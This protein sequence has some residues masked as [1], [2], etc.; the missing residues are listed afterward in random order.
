MLNI[1]WVSTYVPGS[2]FMPYFHMLSQLALSWQSSFIGAGKSRE[3]GPTLWGHIAEGKAGMHFHYALLPWEV[4]TCKYIR[5][6]LVLAG[7]NIQCLQQTNDCFNILK[8]NI[9]ILNN[10]RSI[11]P[12]NPCFSIFSYLQVVLG[13]NAEVSFS[14][15]TYWAS[16]CSCNF[17]V[18]FPSASETE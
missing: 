8:S 9:I 10:F 17:I 6:I 2:Y 3:V 7:S 15:A 1:Y 18:E 12:E 16:M 14:I 11:W 5:P 4:E 13:C